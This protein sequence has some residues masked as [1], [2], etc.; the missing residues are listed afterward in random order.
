MESTIEELKSDVERWESGPE[1]VV[2][3]TNVFLHATEIFNELDLTRLVGNSTWRLLV[4]MTVVDE[5][6]DLKRSTNKTDRGESVRSRARRTLR[7]LEDAAADGADETPMSATGS[8]VEV[9]RDP[10]GHVRL[11]R[12]DDEIV[13]RAVAIQQIAGRQVSLITSDTGMMLRA[14]PLGLRALRYYTEADL[15]QV[16][17]MR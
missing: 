10:P 15:D 7:A 5:L 6:D 3:D 14:R 13:D 12:P 9:V 2:L 11:P 1:L 8:T 4:P 17:C 16:T